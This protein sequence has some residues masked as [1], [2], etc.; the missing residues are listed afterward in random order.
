MLSPT[1]THGLLIRVGASKGMISH[2]HVISCWSCFYACFY[3][4]GPSHGLSF[5]MLA[6]ITSNAAVG[7]DCLHVGPNHLE[8]CCVVGLF[9][10]TRKVLS[11]RGARPCC[12]AWNIAIALS[13]VAL[14]STALPQI[15][16]LLLTNCLR[17]SW[18]NIQG[19]CQRAACDQ[20]GCGQRA[21]TS[22]VNA[23]RLWK[24]R[25]FQSSD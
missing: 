13:S 11:A 23:R 24:G 12:A 20:S 4:G 10:R 15:A 25:S 7:L 9:L 5:N 19:G 2:L 6:L 17:E 16:A 8:C 3:A 21:G 18:G 1:R 14:S 22:P